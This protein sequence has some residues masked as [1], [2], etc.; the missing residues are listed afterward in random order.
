MT[1]TAPV[2]VTAVPKSSRALHGAALVISRNGVAPHGSST[3]VA[4]VAV[5]AITTTM[6]M[7]WTTDIGVDG[8]R[9]DLGRRTIAEV[10]STKVSVWRVNG[11]FGSGL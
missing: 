10:Q 6:M 4:A 1:R 5:V 3:G 9:R 7:L 8:L 11:A 2:D